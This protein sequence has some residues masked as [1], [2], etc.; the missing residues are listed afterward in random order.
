PV[1]WTDGAEDQGGRST[2]FCPVCQR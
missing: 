1:W 2:F